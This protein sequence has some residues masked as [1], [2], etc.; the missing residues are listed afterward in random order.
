MN[1]T[2]SD[3]I[4]T[5][6]QAETQVQTIRRKLFDLSYPDYLNHEEDYPNGFSDLMDHGQEDF[7]NVL[8]RLV[9]TRRM[10]EDDLS[11]LL[12]TP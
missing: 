3:L 11:S 5:L 9:E 10:L 2:I 4:T 1:A 7:F 8:Q 6:Q 12:S